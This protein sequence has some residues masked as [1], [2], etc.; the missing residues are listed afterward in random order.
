MK[1]ARYRV[2]TVQEAAKYFNR[3]EMTIRR[4]CRGGVLLA[5]N[6]RVERQ[7]PGCYLIYVPC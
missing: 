2:L 3:T 5:A 6:C 1:P 4:W 7:K